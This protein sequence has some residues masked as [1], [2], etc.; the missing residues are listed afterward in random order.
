MEKKQSAK[1]IFST[2]TLN[3]K[4]FKKLRLSTVMPGMLEVMEEI[5]R[6]I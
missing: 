2:N 4:N 5:K 3:Q 6:I 1:I